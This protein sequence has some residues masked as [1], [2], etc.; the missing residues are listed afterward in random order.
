VPILVGGQTQTEGEIHPGGSVSLVGHIAES[1][2]WVAERIVPISEDESFFTFAGPLESKD[3]D[4]WQVAG[5]TL[6]L[7]ENTR[8]GEAIPLGEIVLATFQAQPDGSWLALQIQALSA[9]ELLRIPTV[10]PT[11]EPTPTPS[12]TAKRPTEQ[13]QKPPLSDNKPADQNG[14]VTVCHNPSKKQGGKTMVI[15]GPALSSH[16]GHGDTLGP[17]R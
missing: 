1:G 3:K 6:A 14:Q 16:L 5:V 2:R 17:C 8:L 12:P 11:P 7:N 4:S 10:T 13:I 9:L 15:D